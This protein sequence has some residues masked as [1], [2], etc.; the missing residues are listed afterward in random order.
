VKGRS[1]REPSSKPCKSLH[2]GSAAPGGSTKTSRD[3]EKRKDNVQASRGTTCAIQNT[4]SRQKVRKH[5]SNA[6]EGK[7]G[8]GEGGKI[9]KRSEQGAGYL[10][11]RK[12]LKVPRRKD[13]RRRRDSQGEQ[14][15]R[16]PE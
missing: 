11:W 1:K 13:E 8:K 16:G 10:S 4:R 6:D 7:A 15:P 9:H 5:R 14:T 12:G 3:A 2:I